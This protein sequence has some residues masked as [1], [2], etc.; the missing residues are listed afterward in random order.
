MTVGNRDILV[1]QTFE[2]TAPPVRRTIL[3]PAVIG[4]LKKFLWQE[5]LGDYVG[6]ETVYD[7]SSHLPDGA[8]VKDLKVYLDPQ[9][10]PPVL[11]EETDWDLSDGEIT[12]NENL[13]VSFELYSRLS[14]VDSYGTLVPKL[15]KEGRGFVLEDRSVNFNTMG[16]LGHSEYGDSVFFYNLPESEGDYFKISNVSPDGKK[17][18]FQI[19]YVEEDFWIDLEEEERIVL[20]TEAPTG[21]GTAGFL[22]ID[23][24]AEKYYYWDSVGETFVEFTGAT[25]VSGETLPLEGGYGILY[26]NT[27]VPETPT[28]FFW[29]A[30]EVPSDHELE[31]L[32]LADPGKIL[33]GYGY[34]ISRRGVFS[35]ENP[36]LSSAKIKVNVE[37]VRTDKK[38]QVNYIQTPADLSELAP[39]FFRNEVAYGANLLF[40]YGGCQVAYV[41]VDEMTTQDVAEALTLLE[42]EEVYFVV[43]MS[44]DRDILDLCVGHVNFMS[45]EENK[46]ER[47]VYG[48]IKVPDQ[49]NR[50]S[51]GT[52]TV[53]ATNTIRDATRD[54]VSLQVRP[55]D[56]VAFSSGVFTVSQVISVTDLLLTNSEGLTL[57]TGGD[58]KTYSIYTVLDLAAK[59]EYAASIGTSYTDRRLNVLM[60]SSLVGSLTDYDDS[61]NASTITREV[62]SYFINCAIIGSLRLTRGIGNPFSGMNVPLAT[63]FPANSFKR[64]QL[65]TIQAGGLLVCYPDEVTGAPLIMQQITTNVTSVLMQEISIQESA[66]MFAKHIR[67]NMRPLLGNRNLTPRLLETGML[68]LVALLGEAKSEGGIDGRGPIIGEDSELISFSRSSECSD[69]GVA[70]FRIQA[71]VPFNKLFVEMVVSI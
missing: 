46:K 45:A 20:S 22:Y 60:P 29:E 19:E 3:V 21:S 34:S 69:C 12:V 9:I 28:Y 33:T 31:V 17:V 65:E 71:Q 47:R 16:V 1:R 30:A 23:T 35:S 32:F 18:Y 53:I 41:T 68:R 38:G 43:P 26:I 5:E 15:Y 50:V 59:A 24:V 61:G 36:L 4:V 7:L 66:D 8:I 39:V 57:E 44:N 42:E 52:C 27:S 14:S 10:R 67:Q 25:L 37:A 54:F 58:A 62:E 11:L 48:T 51:N 63:G 40:S 64:K 55:G 13:S 49:L 70:R 56:S 6:E 2:E